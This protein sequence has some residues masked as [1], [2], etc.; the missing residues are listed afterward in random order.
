MDDLDER[1]GP[2]TKV[3]ALETL[4]IAVCGFPPLLDTCWRC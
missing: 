4:L 3:S 2:H 1:L